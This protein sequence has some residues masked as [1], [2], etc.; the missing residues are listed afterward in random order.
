MSHRMID[1]SDRGGWYHPHFLRGRPSELALITRTA[2]KK[3][4]AAN[5]AP[6]S[7]DHAHRLKTPN[8]YEMLAIVPD[9]IDN[10]SITILNGGPDICPS[11][12]AGKSDGSESDRIID[13]VDGMFHQNTNES[14]QNLAMVNVAKTDMQVTRR[15]S[16]HEHASLVQTLPQCSSAPN[17]IRHPSYLANSLEALPHSMPTTATY[18]HAPTANY[19]GSNV[20]QPTS[21]GIVALQE[22]YPELSYTTCQQNQILQRHL[23]QQSNNKGYSDL[24]NTIQQACQG[25]RIGDEY[26]SFQNSIPQTFMLEA[27][28][29][30]SYP[31]NTHPNQDQY[32]IGT[33][34]MDSTTLNPNQQTHQIA[35]MSSFGLEYAPSQTSYQAGTTIYHES[36]SIPQA[37]AQ[38][39]TP[40]NIQGTLSL[41]INLGLRNVLPPNHNEVGTTLLTPGLGRNGNNSVC[42]SIDVFGQV[43][44]DECF[45]SQNYCSPPT[46]LMHQ[47]HAPSQQ[48][49]LRRDECL[50]SQN[51]CAPPTTLM[52]QVHAPP[53]PVGLTESLNEGHGENSNINSRPDDIEFLQFLDGLPCFEQDEDEQFD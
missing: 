23:I 40:N 37:E 41:L 1:G 33:E 27:R 7:N 31:S 14:I 32:R 38:L 20:S 4:N 29:Q 15:A 47:V 50:I 46:T 5:V 44:R 9:Q 6:S 42:N 21:A 35:Q 52:H 24:T 49:S 19:I 30:D 18:E 48:V 45:L 16:W 12:N 43:Q 28:A 2:V 10:F 53:Q 3:K 8:F 26:N 51:C 39:S 34:Y 17:E 22:S 13:S 25:A 36:A 11:S